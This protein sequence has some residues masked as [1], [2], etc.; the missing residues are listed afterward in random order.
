MDAEPRF[1]QKLLSYHT[2]ICIHGWHKHTV[3]LLST[4]FQPSL[5]VPSTYIFK[6][7]ANT[8]IE[9][10]HFHVKKNMK[11]LYKTHATQ[12]LVE[13]KKKQKRQIDNF[14]Q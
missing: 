11:A 13:E 14:P 6:Y 4:F 8:A 1:N 10:P 12:K 9:R 7:Q 2:A 5:F 3:I